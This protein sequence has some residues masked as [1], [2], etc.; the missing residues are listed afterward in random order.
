MLQLIIGLVLF[1]G[2]HSVSIVAR[3][4]RNAMVTRL[5]EWPWKGLYSVVSL[6]GLVLI[7]RGYAAARFDPVVLYSPPAWTH[8]VAMLLM[9]VAFPALLA[10]YVPG[11]IQRV[12]K[13][14]MLVAVKA[15]A[16]AH[17]LVTGTLA[18]VVL[19][20]SFLAWA[21]A[22]RISVK[23]RP[24]GATF[25]ARASRANDVIVLVGGLALYLAFVF[26]LH[27]ML[28]GVPLIS[29]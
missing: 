12:L 19:F 21:V 13:H 1:L 4:W 24:Q 10:A 25:Q 2:I 6:I 9:L 26:W 15:W 3:P 17:L 20:G 14:P 29:R 18:A 28:F 16:L 22:D 7:V 23:R 8:H 5:G 27:G 11:G